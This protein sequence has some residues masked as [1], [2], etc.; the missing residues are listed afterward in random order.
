MEALAL[1]QNPSNS[2]QENVGKP[3]KKLVLPE[4]QNTR[5]SPFEVA[6]RSLGEI[7]GDLSKPIADKH[8]ETRYIKDQKITY[9][10]WHHAQKYLDHFAPGWSG[11][12]VRVYTTDERIF[13]VYRI[14]IQAKEGVVSREATGTE[15]LHTDSWGDPSSNAESMAFRRAC[16]RFGLGL[17]LYDKDL[18]LN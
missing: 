11:Q 16:A 15:L 18:R 6:S 2:S 5:M 8:L 17:Y 1:N 12:V 3:L 10:P 4:K 14:A 7:I 13:V 9:I